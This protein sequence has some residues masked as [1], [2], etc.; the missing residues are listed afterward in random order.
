MAGA[1]LTAYELEREDRVAR[2]KR[3]R[4]SRRSPLRVLTAP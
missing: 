2:N 4:P 1:Q 3:V